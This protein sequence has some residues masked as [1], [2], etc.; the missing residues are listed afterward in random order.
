MLHWTPG[1]R[2]V[3]LEH[4]KVH[5]F[6]E[7]K[8]NLRC[9]FTWSDFSPPCF[10]SFLYAADFIRLVKIQAIHVVP[11]KEVRHTDFGW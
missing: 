3:D 7:K 10:P 5:L 8:K 6:K 2:T 1:K 11:D 9:P 4:I